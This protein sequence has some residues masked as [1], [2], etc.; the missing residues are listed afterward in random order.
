[1]IV[2]A[3]YDPA[4]PVMFAAEAA[5]IRQALND[6]AVRIEHVGSTSV[7]ALS[8][9]PVV[10]IQVSV[11]SLEPAYRYRTSL[12]DLGYTHIPLGEFD[13]V[14]PFFKRPVEWPSTHHVHL[15]VADS[16]QERN[17]LAFRDFLRHNPA[18]AAEYIVLKRQLAAVHDGLT[19]ESQER[20]SLSK[21]EFVR[22]V[23]ARAFA[24]GYPFRAPR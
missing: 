2:I 6:L 24:E 21:T 3:P 10:D 15:C 19:L 18:V 4:W 7:P 23:L 12:A 9:K 16:E 13:L 1:M 22:S 5:R 8:A 11:P 17:H 14:Y 20:Y